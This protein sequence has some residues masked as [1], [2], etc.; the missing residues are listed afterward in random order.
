MKEQMVE[1]ARMALAVAVKQAEQARRDGATR[2]IEELRREG[3]ELTASL[4]P[5]KAQ[6][7]EA[8]NERLKLSRQLAVARDQI[9][10]YSTP[11]DP[12]TFPNV[13]NVGV[14]F[15]SDD[16]IAE[17]AAQLELWRK[18]QK[19]LLAAHKAAC[20]RE[21]LR[22][23]AVVLQNRLDHITFELSNQL[24]IAEGRFPGQVAEG[25]VF[26]VGEDLIG[27]G[28]FVRPRG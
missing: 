12:M 9:E 15:P 10:A 27:T 6:V 3:A 13:P 4:K 2:K 24:A 7:K 16:E 5:M 1:A 14:T 23:K 26:R 28:P 22:H 18:E 17:R 19:R 8:Q 11:L 20:E 25:G 21:N